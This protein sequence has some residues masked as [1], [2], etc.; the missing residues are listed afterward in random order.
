MS[1]NLF[2]SH[3][4]RAVNTKSISESADHLKE[5]K[6]ILLQNES[7]SPITEQ[8]LSLLSKLSTKYGYQLSITLAK[9]YKCLSESTPKPSAPLRFQLCCDMHHL[10]SS[11]TGIDICYVLKEIYKLEIS[12]LISSGIFSNEEKSLMQHILDSNSNF[13]QLS[14]VDIIVQEIR[15]NNPFSM[16]RLMDYF[17]GM[18]SIRDQ[19][20]K[21]PKFMEPI[22]SAMHFTME[23]DEGIDREIYLKLLEFIEHFVFRY[24]FNIQLSGYDKSSPM[25]AQPYTIPEIKLLSIYSDVLATIIDLLSI[26]NTADVMITQNLAKILQRLWILYPGQRELLHDLIFINLKEISAGGT[27]EAKAE[28][29]E[30]FWAVMHNKGTSMNFKGKLENE[31]MISAYLQ[32]GV[33]SVMDEVFELGEPTDLDAL[34]ITVG[35]PLCAVIPSGGQWTHLVEV[36]EAQCILSWGFATENYDVSFT[37]QRVDLPE[38]ETIISHAKVRCNETPAA[39]IR[40]LNSQGLYKFTWSN[41]Y[42]WFRAKHLR[43]KVFLLRPYKATK[44]QPSTDLGHV[45]NILNEATEDETD[46]MEIGVEVKNNVLRL[47]A[48]DPNSGEV[49]NYILEEINYNSKAEVLLCISDFTDELVK[50]S[51][52]RVSAVRIGIVQQQLEHIPGIEELGCIAMSRD[53]H[54]VGLLSQDNLQAHT[55]IA[56]IYE[57]GLRSCVVHRGKVLINEQGESIGNLSNFKDIDPE[58]GIGILLCMFGPAQVI[59]TGE[60]F[61]EDL[62]GVIAK[63]RGYVPPHIWKNSSIRE[64]VYKSAA[65]V[66]SAAKLHYLHYKYKFGM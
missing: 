37:L 39:G 55:L 52:T 42:S 33:E 12:Q 8:T 64:S 32:Q 26:L 29:A 31:D 36:P 3:L 66:Q 35:F 13:L 41:S 51:S 49:P 45:I 19:Y 23:T 40:L 9:F 18:E 48:L 38:P 28:A 17:C 44:K 16:N 5:A 47:T 63:I 43:Y 53:V 46:F 6:Q 15:D 10:C 60:S 56:V 54:A 1:T 30:L 27:E 25:F 34:Q 62:G 50:S 57:D 61:P 7:E 2:T 4:Q 21:L 14:A 20:F 11:L 65:A 59:L 22:I 24:N 58:Q